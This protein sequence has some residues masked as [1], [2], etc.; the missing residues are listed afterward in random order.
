MHMF[1]S[2]LQELKVA[3]GSHN[4]DLILGALSNCIVKGT[5]AFCRQN[6]N[7]TNN[8]NSIITF[9]HTN[10]PNVY[11]NR[12]DQH[13]MHTLI[14]I[15]IKEAF[16]QQQNLFQPN[17]VNFGPQNFYQNPYSQQNIVPLNQQYQTV[18][19]NFSNFNTPTVSNFSN[20]NMV[21]SKYEDYEFSTPK[22]D[23]VN[24]QPIE[25]VSNFIEEEK[26][27]YVIGE[28]ECLISK[29]TYIKNNEYCG[30]SEDKTNYNITKMDDP[31]KKE[32]KEILDEYIL[33]LKNLTPYTAVRIE[34]VSIKMEDYI[35]NGKIKIPRFHNMFNLFF[36][37]YLLLGTYNICDD[38][39]T[40][41]EKINTIDRKNLRNKLLDILHKTY[42]K[43]LELNQ[44]V[45]GGKNPISKIR[46][47][48]KEDLIL[49]KNNYLFEA[50]NEHDINTVLTVEKDGYENLYDL[51]TKTDKETFIVLDLNN[52]SRIE[53]VKDKDL[54]NE[55]K[56]I[57]MIT[58][59]E[60]I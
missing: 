17:T 31:D 1:N 15:G 56:F 46:Y 33:G 37:K 34:D 9:L 58:K 38:V 13:K 55:N 28:D 59:K 10:I 19:T 39:K 36:I 54:V 22:Q 14:Q 51:F 35:K 40:I 53:F 4:Q 27:S 49:L 16:G 48:L 2:S 43:A 24:I 41:E 44:E 23:N 57:L 11:L 25:S 6:P 50:L 12:I 8:I 47:E 30:N 7:M 20:S 52:G 21:S 18:N 5:A 26:N 60:I 45:I 29:G 32:Y 42:S 3:A